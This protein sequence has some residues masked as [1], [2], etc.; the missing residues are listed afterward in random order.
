MSEVTEIIDSRPRLFAPGMAIGLHLNIERVLSMGPGRTYYLADNRKPRWYTHIC[1]GCGNK[2]NPANAPI[3]EYCQRPITKRR[4]LLS[5]RWH[6]AGGEEFHQFAALRLDHIAINSPIVLYRYRE[7]L[8]AFH[9][10]AEEALLVDEP[11]PLRPRTLLAGAWTLA[12]GILELM[13]HGIVLDRLGPEHVLVGRN[14]SRLWDLDIREVR[15]RR[16]HP[17]DPVSM[18]A[19]RMLGALMLRYVPMDQAETVAFFHQA[20]VGGF[21]DIATMQRE[22]RG[23]A[24]NLQLKGSQRQASALSSVGR[25]RP[26]NEDSWGWRRIGNIDLFVVADGMGGYA[27]G[28]K[29]SATAVETVTRAASTLLPRTNAKPADIQQALA[30]VV[31]TANFAVQELSKDQ[32]RPTG[33]TLVVLAVWPDGQAWLAHIGDSRA[34]RVRDGKLHPLTEDHSMV[35]AMV[36]AGKLDREGARTHPR[37]NV[38]LQYLGSPGESDPDINKADLKAGDRVLICSDGLWG[39]M[40]ES[41]LEKLFDPELDLR[42]QVR[43][44]VSAAN[45]SGGK[46]NVTALLVTL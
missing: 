45:D 37:S 13:E 16:I 10:I 26:N 34:Y 12:A 9:E 27:A 8:L 31:S 22:L 14:G 24:R 36:E 40:P 20:A 29:A 19:A 33:T 5:C 1:W 42:R 17:R 43:V 39:E 30:E 28:D 6:E 41:E 23:F 15:G 2:H 25:R 3:C 7:Q 18:D 4:F 44:L 32:E 38:L 21:P 46:D 11:S 35:Q